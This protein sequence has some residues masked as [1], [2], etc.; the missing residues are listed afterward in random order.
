[1]ILDLQEAPPALLEAA[2]DSL[3]RIEEPVWG[4]DF[5]W[6][7]GRLGPH[8]EIPGYLSVYLAYW[9]G[10]PACSGR[11]YFHPRSLFAGLFGGS[12]LSKYRNRGLYT[13]VLA[14]RALEAAGRGY[15]FLA[16]GASRMSQPILVANGFRLLTYSHALEWDRGAG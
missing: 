5:S 16:T 9:E 13:S 10:Q 14:I 15:R 12:T 2:G 6:L 4:E 3:R 1:M 11:I 8:T 7:K